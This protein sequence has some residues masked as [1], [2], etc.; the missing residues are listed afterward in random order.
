MGYDVVIDVWVLVRGEWVKGNTMQE[1]WPGCKVDLGR[2]LASVPMRV[3]VRG[4]RWNVL[5]SRSRFGVDDPEN[6]IH[7]HD[8]CQGGSTSSRLSA[9]RCPSSLED[10]GTGEKDLGENEY[11]AVKCEEGGRSRRD[12]ERTRRL[13]VTSH[14]ASKDSRNSGD[15]RPTRAQLS[16]LRNKHHV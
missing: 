1:L 5:P 16:A 7:S 15:V 3:L 6:S 10:L 8:T 12:D 4:E 14:Q 2:R 9:W 11:S 13:P